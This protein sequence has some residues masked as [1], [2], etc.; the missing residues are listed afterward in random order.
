MW[1]SEKVGVLYGGCSSERAISLKSG[2]SVYKALKNQ[3]INAYLFDTGKKHL[4]ELEKSDFERVFI[5][6]HGCYG[7]DGSIQGALELM[8]IPYTGSGPLASNLAMNKVMAKRIWLQ[9]NLTTPNFKLLRDTSDFLAIINSFKLPFL[10]K[11][12]RGGSTLGISKVKNYL[13]M[14]MAYKKALSYDVH[15]FSEEFISGRELTVAILEINS[16]LHTLPIVEINTDNEI[17]SYKSKYFSNKTQYF[18]PALLSPE[19]S[20]KVSDI[21]KKAYRSLECAGCARIDVI[22]DEMERPWLLELN[23]SPGMTERSLVPIAANQIGLSYEKLC[24]TILGQASCK[25]C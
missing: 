25:L 19:A 5:A 11:P 15:V 14:E 12:L 24:L 20:K 4:S 23:T 6:L 8:R 10:M 22:L 18:C 16:E 7:E 13:D 1:V 3:G 17:Y 9:N 2:L 21:A